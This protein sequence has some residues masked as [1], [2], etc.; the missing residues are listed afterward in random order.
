MARLFFAFAAATASVAAAGAPSVLMVLTSNDK[1]GDKDEKGETGWY[2]PEAAHPFNVFKEAGVQMTW[3]SPKG[4]KA[5][6]DK[7]SVEAYAKDKEATAF[8]GEQ[9]WQH[10][11]VLKNVDPQDFDAVFVVGGYGVM[12]DLVKDENM[13]K[14]A[15]KIY[16]DGGI[17]SGVCHGPAALVGVKLSDGRSLVKGKKVACF[18]NAEEDQ[19]GRRKVVPETCEDS[20][21]DA[22]AKYTSDE[23][24]SDHV[25]VSG[26]LITGQNPTS[27]KST[28]EAVV[29]ALRRQSEEEDEEEAEKFQ[30]GEAV[31][32]PTGWL[33]ASG[34]VFG[35]AFGALFIGMTVLVFRRRGQSRGMT[36]VASI[37]DGDHLLE[38][39][40]SLD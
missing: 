40:E 26:R 23:P 17:V 34:A 33:A 10:T 37:E 24:W 11:E 18:S 36:T 7:G 9:V 22:G 14:I 32:Q 12:W 31:L 5:P 1:L 29:K 16:E 39:Q 28:A 20:F 19:V 21:K 27:A 30:L 25:S 15:A 38:D 6:V 2:L 13:K 4:G 8:L 3:A 35:V